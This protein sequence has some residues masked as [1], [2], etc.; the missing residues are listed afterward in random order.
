MQN[1]TVYG[2]TEKRIIIKSGVFKESI[3]SLNIKTLGGLT[4]DEKHDKSGT[5]TLGSNSGFSGVFRETGWLGANGNIAPA[6][7]MI[8]NARTVYQKIIELQK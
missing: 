2:I 8:D 6:I 7:E 5:I 3:K 4:L 1:Q